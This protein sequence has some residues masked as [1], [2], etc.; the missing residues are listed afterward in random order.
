MLRK[1]IADPSHVLQ[2]LPVELKQDLSFDVQLM[3]IVDQKLKELSNK[4][5]PMVKIL[6]SNNAI[7]EMMWETKAS[8]KSCY[9]YLFLE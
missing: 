7:K 2:A 9:P 1:Y 6:W 4:V 5:I 3:G 8:M